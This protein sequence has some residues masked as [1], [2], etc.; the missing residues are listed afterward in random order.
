MDGTNMF[1]ITGVPSTTNLSSM[2]EFA[3]PL[4]ILTNG[5]NMFLY[6]NLSTFD[7]ALPLIE[8]GNSMF[9]GSSNLESFK[10][11]LSTLTHG[12]AMFANCSSL[13]H[14]M[15][16]L[17]SLKS[18]GDMFSGCK[19]D[20]ESLMYIADSINTGSGSL[21][22]IAIKNN[23]NTLTANEIE[24]LNEIHNKGWAVHVNGNRYSPIEPTGIM[25]LDE[26]GEEKFTPIPFWAKAIPCEEK[27]AR[28]ID[29]EGNFFTIVG[30][31]LILVDDPETYGMFTCEADA[32]AN[33]R[34]TKY[35]RPVVEET[36]EVE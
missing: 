19:L 25:T 7:T 29:N 9:A 6:S 28:Y 17:S 33:M 34:L 16:D 12:H 27:D 10:S 8:N 35:V 14:F 20:E 1:R 31:Q 15:G 36:E 26:N 2:S 11:D 13:E 30:G 24:Y 3:S 4:P 23:I 5:E 22:D 21:M 18:A 32:A